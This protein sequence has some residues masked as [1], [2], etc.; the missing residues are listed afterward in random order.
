M[1]KISPLDGSETSQVEVG[2]VSNQH[3]RGDVLEEV[4]CSA[5]VEILL[6]MFQNP[7][8]DGLWTGEQEGGQPG[9][10]DHQPM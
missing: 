8:D 7:E 10:D 3:W 6:R 5:L 1:V 2:G 4:V 9:K